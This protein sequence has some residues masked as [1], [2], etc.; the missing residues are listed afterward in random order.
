MQVYPI[1]KTLRQP[2][3]LES[4]P[5]R[6][7]G[8]VAPPPLQAASLGTI[9]KS[10][11]S[12]A[13]HRL[14]RWA[15]QS[16]AR[17][18]LPSERVSSCLRTIS[19][20]KSPTPS[21]LQNFLSADYFQNVEILRTKDRFH[22]G[23]L[24]TCGSVWHC[25]ICAAKIS[26]L[27]R[28]ELT[29]AVKNCKDKGGQVHLLTLTVPHYSHQKVKTV[30]AG[31][32]AALQRLT[33]SRSFKSLSSRIGLFG[34]I[35]SLEVTYGEN[36]WHPHFHL[37][38]FTHRPFN[39]A[40]LQAELLDLWKVACVR[41]SLP[42][43][44]HHG[45]KLDNGELAAQYVGKWGIEHEMTKGHIKK[46]REGYSPFDL[47]RVQIGG[48]L[49][50]RCLDDKPEK[51]AELF[52]EY[53]KAFKGKR[54]LVWSKDLRNMLLSDLPELTDEEAADSVDADAELFALV[55][56]SIWK[57]VL[58]KKLR[59]VVLE[60]CRAG[61]DVLGEYLQELSDKHLTNEGDLCAE[62]SQIQLLSTTVNDALQLSL[63]LTTDQAKEN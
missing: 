6:P 58:K 56:L 23:N 61:A 21:T 15:M 9:T 5:L 2:L 32:S 1:I 27:R 39:I 18:I 59:G 37:L 4:H 26:E 33:N 48:S 22:Y 14:E 10:L 24:T 62:Q 43:P 35:R 38:L 29:Q 51:A 53:A 36:G 46:S 47:L 12:P 34:R 30:L 54:Q 7:A 63:L 17:E 52:R 11:N 55:P 25:P 57:I 40:Y 16:A 13:N 8:G 44:N 20:F 28:V 45:V 19:K 31:L 50:D 49:S 60:K 3:P 42:E 41:S